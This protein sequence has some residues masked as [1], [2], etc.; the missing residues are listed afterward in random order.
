MAATKLE[1]AAMANMTTA[2][3]SPVGVAA[4]HS[5]AQHGWTRVT[6]GWNAARAF[7]SRRTCQER[8]GESTEMRAYPT[9][10]PI[11]NTDCITP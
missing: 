9:G 7:G 5:T 6:D 4:K 11:P 1:R 10:Y 2:K 8:G 3:Q